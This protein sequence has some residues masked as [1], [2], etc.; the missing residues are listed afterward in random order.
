MSSSAA[1]ARSPR[2]G[3]VFIISRLPMARGQDHDVVRVGT[4]GGGQCNYR[5]S[6]GWLLLPLRPTDR[7]TAG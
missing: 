2:R 5:R 7:P 1:A 3:G 4:D 6:K